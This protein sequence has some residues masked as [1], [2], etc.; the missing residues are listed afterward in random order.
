[1]LKIKI[2]GLSRRGDIEC[3]N[4]LLPDYVGFVFAKSRRQVTPEQ[5]LKLKQLLAPQIQAVGVFVN[6]TP[7]VIASLVEQ[8]IIDCVQLHGD[9]TADYCRQLR[10]LVNVPIIKAVRVR[11]AGSLQNLDAFACD[12]LLLDTYTEA[13]YGG[14]GQRFDL[15]LLKQ[16][17]LPKPYFIAGGLDAGNVQETAR[18]AVP[19]GVDVSGGVETAGFKDAKKITAFINAVRNMGV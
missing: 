6:E 3:V 12:Y 8:G 4:R 18:Q 14:S 19:Y 13:Q 11:D 5:A 10:S 9:E 7:R 16:A 17:A 1:M 15:E 2:C